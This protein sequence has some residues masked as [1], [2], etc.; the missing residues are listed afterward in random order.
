MKLLP[1]LC[2]ILCL[3]SCEARK[4]R[5]TKEF[6]TVFE[7]SEGMETATYIQTIDFYIQLAKEFPEINI[8]TIGNTDSGNPL[9]IVT[10]NADAEFNF[11]KIG[12]NKTIILVNNGIHPGESDGIDATML[13][14]R[15]LVLKKRETLKNTVLVTI[16]IYNIG[17]ALNRNAT[18][19][20]N[21]NG[22]KS[23]GFRGN[24]R[25]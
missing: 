9:H 11:Q 10:Y 1:A 8:Q 4:E 2:I 17:G 15:D 19:R 23:Y 13:L 5:E 14:Y 16:P 12:K 20:V 21:Q 3:I 18:S 7:Q 25:N 6:R 22:P 24:V